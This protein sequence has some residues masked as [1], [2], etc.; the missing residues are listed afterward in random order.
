MVSELSKD[1]FISFNKHLSGLHWSYKWIFTIAF[2]RDDT[3]II[4]WILTTRSAI[5]VFIGELI[6]VFMRGEDVEL[7]VGLSCTYKSSTKSSTNHQP[8]H[9]FLSTLPA[10]EMLS[11]IQ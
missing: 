1:R 10:L 4:L 9:K 6:D 8:L 11:I 2:N 3:V 7:G 5:D